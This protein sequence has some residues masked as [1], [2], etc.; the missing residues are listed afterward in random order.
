MIK[1]DFENE[2]YEII[3]YKSYILPPPMSGFSM[4]LYKNCFYVFGGEKELDDRNFKDVFWKYDI[5]KNEWSLEKCKSKYSPPGT[6]EN[7]TGN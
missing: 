3:K 1:Y 4:N 2:K 6:L 7:H 5:E